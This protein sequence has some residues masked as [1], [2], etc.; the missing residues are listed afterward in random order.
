MAVNEYKAALHIQELVN[1]PLSRVIAET[2]FKLALAN[3]VKPDIDQAT[4]HLVKAIQLLE[5]R[6]QWLQITPPAAASDD[7]GKGKAPAEDGGNFAGVGGIVLEP[8]PPPEEAK[9]EIQEI[10]ELLEALH[11]KVRDNIRAI[12]LLTPLYRQQKE[13]YD[14]EAKKEF[15]LNEERKNIIRAAFGELASLGGATPSASSSASSSSSAVPAP[16]VNAFGF[17]APSAAAAA[18]P[19]NDLSSVVRKRKAPDAAPAQVPAQA[20]SAAVK[21]EEADGSASKA[22]KTEQ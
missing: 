15:Q 17:A 13:D 2:H 20:P 8:L 16:A 12:T 5:A 21:P 9:V 14:L 18:A 1:P 7:K 3:E 6:V 11:Q 22:S 10:Q 19:V 4:V